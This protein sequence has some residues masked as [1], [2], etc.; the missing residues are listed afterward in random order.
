[1]LID[2]KAYSEDLMAGRPFHF[3]AGHAII[4]II[5]ELILKGEA[6]EKMKTHVDMKMTE[7]LKIS[8]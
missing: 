2:Y 5:W 6:F 8:G 4:E 7:V 3:N 1:M